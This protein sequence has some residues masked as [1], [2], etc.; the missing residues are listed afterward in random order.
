MADRINSA[1]Y[2]TEASR[3]LQ[4]AALSGDSAARVELMETAQVFRRMADDIE[5][6]EAVNANATKGIGIA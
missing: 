1:F 2:R 6:R 4:L 5:K 3:L